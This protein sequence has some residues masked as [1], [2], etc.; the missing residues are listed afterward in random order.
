MC[1]VTKIH[2]LLSPE[3]IIRYVFVYAETMICYILK[4]E[5]MTYYVISDETLVSSLPLI[6]VSILKLVRPRLKAGGGRGG[7]QGTLNVSSY[8]SLDAAATVN[9]P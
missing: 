9:S 7:G 2:Y 5:T 6:C 4:V 8:V 1:A 3:T